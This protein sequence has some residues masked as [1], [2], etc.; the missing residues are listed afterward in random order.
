LTCPQPRRGGELRGGTC[1]R[2]LRGVDA[3][4]A[5]VVSPPQLG[6]CWG[7]PRSSPPSRA[8]RRRRRCAGAPTAA[9]SCAAQGAQPWT[10]ARAHA[11]CAR[12]RAA[13]CTCQPRLPDNRVLFCR[14]LLLHA[15]AALPECVHEVELVVNAAS[16]ADHVATCRRSARPA[17]S[18]RRPR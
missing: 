11:A 18:T 16:C 4:G 13:R 17:A 7:S 1:R 15:P 12:A 8:R 3:G 5:N 9:R 10:A 6:K 14:A 2:L